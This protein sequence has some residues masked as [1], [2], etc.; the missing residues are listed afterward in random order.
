MRLPN[1]WKNSAITQIS[2][3]IRRFDVGALRKHRELLEL[4]KSTQWETEQVMGYLKHR[5]EEWE[6]IRENH[7]W[8]NKAVSGANTLLRHTL[9]EHPT[10]LLHLQSRWLLILDEEGLVPAIF[11]FTEF[12]RDGLAVSYYRLFGGVALAWMPELTELVLDVVNSQKQPEM[13]PE[14]EHPYKELFKFHG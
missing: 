1:I 14:I 13:P 6:V 10:F 12:A 9:G 5:S 2:S 11:L 7:V 8:H 4:V 3:A